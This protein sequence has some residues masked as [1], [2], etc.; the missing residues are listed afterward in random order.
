MQGSGIIKMIRNLAQVLVKLQSHRKMYM[1]SRD[2]YPVQ[3][4]I[5]IYQIYQLV[6]DARQNLYHHVLV[7]TYS[8]TCLVIR[9]SISFLRGGGGGSKTGLYL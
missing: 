1:G 6:G 4:D 5:I 2:I 3:L 8:F 9:A 7:K